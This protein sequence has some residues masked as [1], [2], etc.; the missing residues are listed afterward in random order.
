MPGLIKIGFTFDNVENRMKQ[1]FTSGVPSPFLLGASFLVNT[2]DKCEKE[3][4]K[5]LINY[6]DTRQ[7]EFF[8]IELTEAIRSAIEIIYRH[9]INFD[10]DGNVFIESL[11]KEIVSVLDEDDIYFLQFILHDSYERKSSISTRE[12]S[13]HHIKYHPFELEIKLD[14][15]SEM[16]LIERFKNKNDIL[17]SWKIS[18]EGI[19]FMFNNNY[20]LKNLIEEQK[21]F[22]NE[23]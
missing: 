2:P 14:R 17:S 22:R 3:I 7:R 9:A 5:I 4:H 12:L 18:Q 21:I 1:L 8:K 10:K 23:N 16:G 6:R 20:E 13:E 11:D 15:L 19:K